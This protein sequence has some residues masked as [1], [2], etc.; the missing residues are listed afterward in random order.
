LFPSIAGRAA[1]GGSPPAGLAAVARGLVYF[2]PHFIFCSRIT[3]Q[4]RL[5]REAPAVGSRHGVPWSK[6]W[7]T[8]TYSDLIVEF[9]TTGLSGSDRE[10]DYEPL[11]V[12]HFHP[13][14][15][16]EIFYDLCF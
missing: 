5:Y 11:D 16:C 8:R 10:A 6:D 2:E 15:I 4:F 1:L 14:V 12:G 3:L 9:C 13:P 7:P